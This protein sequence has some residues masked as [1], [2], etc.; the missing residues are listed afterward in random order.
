MRDPAQQPAAVD[1]AQ[2][3]SAAER[4]RHLVKRTPLYPVAGKWLPRGDVRLLLKLECQH[5]ADCVRE[6][7]TPRSDGKDGLRVVRVL[8]AAQRS[9]E[10][11]GAPVEV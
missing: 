1:L 2:V 4:I 5:F 9:L 10:Q 11:N 3:E 6:G 7:K 8:A